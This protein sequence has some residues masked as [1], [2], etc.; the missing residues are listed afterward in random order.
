MYHWY[1][2]SAM[3]YA[4]L[5]DVS[6]GDDLRAPQS[7]FRTSRWYTRG[8]T[9]QELIAPSFVTFLSDDW[10]VI[11]TK[12]SLFDL[13]EEITGI[14]SEVLLSV[15]PL[16]EFSVAQRLSWAANRETT[17]V[18]DRAYSL[19][20]IF[21]INMP[22]LY[23]EGELAFRRLQEEIVRRVPDQSIFAWE[24]IYVRLRP[25][26]DIVDAWSGDQA[27]VTG[28]P[29]K[30][31][32]TRRH[33][34][35]ATCLLAPDLSMFIDA[36]VIRA[37]S[38]QDVLRLVLP[39]LPVPEYTFTPH[40]IRTQLPL[41]PISLCL[42]HIT[43]APG[44]YLGSSYL[45]ILGCEHID[46]PDHLLGRFCYILPSNSGV[47]YLYSGYARFNRGE[48]RSYGFYGLFPLSPATI[49]RCR[50]SIRVRTVYICGQPQ[51]NTLEPPDR[52]R[53]P[54]ERISLAL[55]KGNVRDVLR[56]SGY[57]AELRITP[58][59]VLTLSNDKH[60]MTV[61]F[62][63]TLWEDG[64]GFIMRADAKMSRI[65]HSPSRAEDAN[66]VPSSVAFWDS[67]PWRDS[68][69][70]EVI[71]FQPGAS[72]KVVLRLSMAY[73]RAA[74]YVLRVKVHCEATSSGRPESP[75]HNNGV[76]LTVRI[77]PPEDEGTRV[78]RTS[79]DGRHS[80]LPAQNEA[81]IARVERAG[82][83]EVERGRR[84]NALC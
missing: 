12:H 74:L 47:D 29:S 78:Q 71:V 65:S 84:R 55:L 51:R 79:D 6:P 53:E 76:G 15:E 36:C 45:A 40:G 58:D 63:R 16:D 26:V 54:H 83:D 50:A 19:L 4:Y 73:A 64:R 42:P 18:E 59:P 39:D 14:P 43:D 37:V 3:C 24:K 31:W 70:E 32:A 77:E 38:H 25:R 41:V 49:E 69:N 17:R 11:G 81:G 22:T 28:W 30:D 1:G 23:G 68:L 67:T 44:S 2:R 72:E 33:K 8:W 10:T 82:E 34:D 75:G 5:A 35:D 60:V 80:M 20:G 56:T 7:S 57:K 61:E 62:R 27:K 9:L 13:I 21:N 66:A 52:S 46:Y 48:E